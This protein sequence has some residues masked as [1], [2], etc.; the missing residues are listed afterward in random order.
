MTPEL[1]NLVITGV[2]IVA[3]WALRHWGIMAPGPTPT[4]TP[5]PTPAPVPA[6]ANPQ[7]LPGLR[8][9]LVDLLLQLLQQL[10]ENK[11]V[12]QQQGTATHTVPISLGFEVK[13]LPSQP[14]EER[15]TR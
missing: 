9:P 8:G 2:A 1:I 10:Q 13:H 15:V 12:P 4:P 3:G 5:T 14:T 6:P 7:P 11:A